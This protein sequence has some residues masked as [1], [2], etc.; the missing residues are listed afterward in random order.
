MKVEQTRLPGVLFL[1]PRVFR[2]ARGHFLETWNEGRYQE[3]GVPGPFVQ[4]NVSVSAR[5]VLR[6][7]HFQQPNPQGKLVSVLQGEVYDV[8]V[9]IRVGSP[10]FG[11]WL[12]C[13]LSG[14]D[15][16]QLYIPPGFAHG[17]VV[18]SP[19]AVFAYKC[20]AYYDPDAEGTLLWNDPAIGI[21]WPV[22]EPLL[23]DKD[24]SGLPLS[25]MPSARLPTFPLAP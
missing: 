19:S 15:G 6:G 4:D 17:F 9:D 7:L 23:S 21:E 13:T 20:T 5:G 22:S 10:T 25:K 14:E 16:R 24:A 12:G 3:L 2:D 1:E 11:E 18:L 8:A